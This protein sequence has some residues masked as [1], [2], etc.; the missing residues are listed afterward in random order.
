M[1]GITGFITNKL[2]L[3][4]TTLERMNNS[5]TRRGPD[6]AGM[7]LE[8]NVGLAM[9]RLSI[10]DLEGGAQPIYNEDN[11]I[12]VFYNG[13]I[14][15]SP[16]LRE[17]L[18]EK[19]HCFRTHTDT[20]VL[21][22][23]YEEYGDDL[24]L[25]L[26]GMFAFA[27]WDK[28]V[29]RVLI[30]RDHLGIKPLF[31]QHDER[32]FFFGSEIKC[33]KEVP[34]QQFSLNYQALDFYLAYTYI[35]APHTIYNEIKKLPAG[36]LLVCE[37]DNISIKEYWDLPSPQDIPQNPYAKDELL[38]QAKEKITDSVKAHLLSDVPVG[39]FLS[40]GVDSSLVTAIMAEEQEATVETF[41]MSFS[42]DEIPLSDERVYAKKVSDKYQTSY[43]DFLVP[44][45]PAAIFPEIIR[46]FDEPF[47][48]DSVFPSYYI[49]QLTARKL[50]VAL[51]GLGGDEIF[52]GYN[53]YSGLLLSRYYS[54]VPKS[55][56]KH[57]VDPILQALPEPKNGGEKVDHLKRFSASALLSPA[58]RYVGYLTA[59]NEGSRKRL[60]KKVTSEKID[61]NDTK[62]H[63]TSLFES[64]DGDEI[65]KAL[66][67]DMKTYL[68]EDILALSD[69]LSM[70]HSLEVRVPLAT[71]S[72]FEFGVNI[73]TS[74]KITLK[75]KKLL[76][77][78]VA[79][80][81]V[82]EEVV[83]HKKQGF[84]APMANWLRNEMKPYC[85][86]I[87]SKDKIEKMGV[88]DSKAV[89]ALVS[90]H[91][92]GRSKNNKVLFS[93]MVFCE[94]LNQNPSIRL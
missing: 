6:D 88:F 94:W 14:Y 93:L 25:H 38:A 22:H 21:V 19:G 89:D 73:P 62:E 15:N 37:N 17:S 81:Y 72:L 59:I 67:T 85:Q 71:P 44:P 13:E 27:L 82:P 18:I 35:P 47:A 64:Y 30:A 11:N 79:L 36:H 56:H 2:R 86:D 26:E 75:G 60:Y 65:S 80:D 31:Y 90:D 7:L 42:G 29:D 49:C 53:R 46:A 70:W 91:M 51:S 66:Y 45:D 1:C 68:P 83:K 20:E 3:D 28:T 8:G 55:F 52:A 77:K 84:E 54:F 9:R 61:F 10:V 87:L 16:A 74:E 32:G 23:L 92:A 39:S 50:K 76:L 34:D 48:D 58:E 4:E 69:R 5:I 24:V 12:C 43:N 40:G 63:F 33:L 57:V 78:D 41:T